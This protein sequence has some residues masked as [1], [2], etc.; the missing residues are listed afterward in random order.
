[1]SQTVEIREF[2]ERIESKRSF[3]NMITVGM[4]MVSVG[5]IHLIE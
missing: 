4:D 3:V 5:L 2:N 1:M